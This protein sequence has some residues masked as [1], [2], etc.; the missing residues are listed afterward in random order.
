MAQAVILA[1]FCI[2]F[3]A[4]LIISGS[5]TKLD[6]LDHR[7]LSP[8]FVPLLVIVLSIMEMLFKE[9]RQKC[10]RQDESE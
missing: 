1:I 3:G 2:F 4:L 8:L 10:K 5:S 9:V 6:N 7:L